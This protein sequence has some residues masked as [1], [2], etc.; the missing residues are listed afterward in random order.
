MVQ[1]KGNHVKIFLV[2]IFVILG[3][4]AC[5]GHD[6]SYYDRANKANDKAQSSLEKE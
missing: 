5:T 4:S 3:F 6:N 1:F 2:S